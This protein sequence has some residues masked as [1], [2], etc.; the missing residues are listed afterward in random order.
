MVP[1]EGD[2]PWQEHLA[3]SLMG[4]EAERKQ[5]SASLSLTFPNDLKSPPPP[6]PSDRFCALRYCLPRTNTS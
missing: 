6:P 4:A 5:S 1:N 2:A 3:M